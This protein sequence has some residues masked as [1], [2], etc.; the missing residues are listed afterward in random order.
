MMEDHRFQFS[1]RPVWAGILAG[2][3]LIIGTFPEVSLVFSPGIDPALSFLFNHLFHSGPAAGKEIIFPHGPLSFLTYPLPENYLIYLVLLSG[4]KILLLT[5]L[6]LLSA[7]KGIS[8]WSIALLFAWIISM[9]AG[10][11]ALL[12]ITITVFL[13]ASERKG[14][15]Y[16]FV[17]AFFLAAFAMFIRSYTA[18]MAGL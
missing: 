16:L 10:F 4:L 12:L 9:L 17:M 7:R 13:C 2:I 6:Y 3:L 15:H 8:G 11:Q 14:Y 1:F 5:G 18:I